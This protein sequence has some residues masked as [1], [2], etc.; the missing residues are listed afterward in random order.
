[1]TPDRKV[2][3]IAEPRLAIP[4]WRLAT[5]ALMT[6]AFVLAVAKGS[7]IA[8]VLIGVLT[9]PSLAVLGAWIFVTVFRR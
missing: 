7:V 8:A 6:T 5:A 3:V 1:M 2:G 4:W 9:L